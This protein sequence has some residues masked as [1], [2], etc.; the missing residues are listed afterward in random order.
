VLA[1]A[2]PR[3]RELLARLVGAF[4]VEPADV[5]ERPGDG[6]QA[7]SLSSRLARAKAEAIAARRPGAA[8]LGSDTVVAVDDDALGKPADADDARSMLGRLSGRGHDVY[9]AIALVT[10]AGELLE[11]LAATRV[12]FA[13]LPPAWVEAYVVSGEPMDKAGAYGI[14]GAAGAWIPRIDGSYSGVVGLPLY[15]TARLLRAGGVL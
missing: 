11:D 12:W 1:S 3:R 8:V 6:E 5:D 15:Q 7:A 14:Q 13:E 9:S 10:A 2:S 4:D